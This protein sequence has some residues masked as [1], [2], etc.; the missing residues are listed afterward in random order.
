MIKWKVSMYVAYYTVEY[1][2]DDSNAAAA[3]ATAVMRGKYSGTTDED[4]PV[5]VSLTAVF[6]EEEEEKDE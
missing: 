5:K 2:F 6:P 3:F 4:V 1:E